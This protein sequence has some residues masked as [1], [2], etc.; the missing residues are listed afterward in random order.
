MQKS[1]SSHAIRVG[2]FF[3]I[4]YLLC[5]VWQMWSTDAAIQTFHLTSLK[6]MFP[7]FTGF[8]L[9]SIIWGGILSFVYGFVGSYAFHRFHASC[10][11]PQK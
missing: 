9:F 2:G 10:C 6:F 11:T 8:T 4:L 7:G 3:I 1:L 5:L